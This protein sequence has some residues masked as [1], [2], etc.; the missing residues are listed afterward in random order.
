MVHPRLRFYIVVTM[1]LTLAPLPLAMAGTP[2]WIELRPGME[3]PFDLQVEEGEGLT[4]VRLRVH[5]FYRGLLD[6][7]GSRFESVTIPGSGTLRENGRPELPTFG[8]S[9]LLGTGA[10]VVSVERETVTVDAIVPSPFVARPKRCTGT[11]VERLTCDTEL[12]NGAGAFPESSFELLQQGQFRGQPAMALELRP[13][14]FFPEQRQL[15]V[16]VE[17]RVTLSSPLLRKANARLLSESFDALSR[18]RFHQL[19]GPTRDEG[20]KE[21]LLLVVHDDLLSSVEDFV[22]WKEEKGYLVVVMPLS[23][24]GATHVELKATLQNA[25]D[26]WPLP[27]TYVL[28]LGDGNGAGKVPFVPSPYGCASDFLFSTLDGDDLYSDVLVGRVSAHTVEEAE[29]QLGKAIWYERDLLANGD[30]EWLPR[31]ICISSSEGSGPSNDDV[32]SEIIC[33]LQADYGFSPTDRLYHSNG[34]DKAA[35]ISGKIEEGRGWLTYLGH[36]S[37]HSW[38]TTEPPYGTLEVTAL[39]NEYRLPFVV[40]VSCSN[41]EFD[42]NAGDCF[43]EVWMKTG[44]ANGPRAAIA[45]YSAS[46]VTPWDEPAEMAVGMTKAALEEGIYGWSALAAA[47]RSYMMETVPGGSHEEVCHQYVVFGDPSLQVRTAQPRVLTVS[48]PPVLPLG[49]FPFAVVVSSEDLPVAGATVALSLP[50]G[51]TV[52]AKTAGDGKA[53]LEVVTGVVGEALLTVTAA[54]AEPYQATLDTLVPGCGLLQATPAL[55]Q[56]EGALDVQ[57]FD[58]DLNL[59][60][61]ALDGVVV[62]ASSDS[63]PQGI[64]VA[65]VETKLDS[66]KFV[67]GLT[68]SPSGEGEALKVG[69]SETVTVSYLDEACEDGAAEKTVDVVVDCTAPALSELSIEEVTATSGIVSFVTN[70]FASGTVRFGLFEPLGEEV[71]YG[72]GKAHSVVLSGLSPDSEIFAEVSLEDVAGNESLDDN[73]GAYYV[74]ETLPCSP[75]CEGKQCGPDGCGALCGGCCEGQTCEAG[76]CLGGPGCEVAPVPGCSE[77]SCE[78]CVCDVDPYCCQVMWD[79]LCVGECVDQCGGCGSTP[80]CGEKECGPNGCGG[81][82]GE[83]PLGW[84]CTDG[85]KCVDNCE[86]DCSGSDC[87][88]DGCGGNCGTCEEG[89]Q[90]VEGACLEECGGIDFVGCCDGDIQ[91]YCEDGFQLLVDCA[92]Q[93]LTCGWKETLGWYDCSDSSLSDPSGTFPLW[94]PGVCPPECDGKECGPDGCGG[95]CGECQEG[96]ECANALCIQDC[97]PNCDGQSCGDDGCG[98]LCECPIGTVCDGGQCVNSCIPQCTDLDCGDDS[99]EGSCGQCAPG[100]SCSV[101]QCVLGQVDDDIVQ[102]SDVI[103]DIGPA[104]SQPSSGCSAGEGANPWGAIFM[105][106]LILVVALSRRTSLA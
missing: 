3:H 65:L 88:T 95:S 40:D 56:C 89:A 13:F 99:C 77:C 84:D 29:R 22:A 33:N 87:G 28:L 54:N 12:Y 78:D 82:C 86:A 55:A 64:A 25:Y 5:G 45:I 81:V 51:G 24:A 15:E 34:T 7:E 23:E 20:G 66:G 11:S 48:H 43:A 97:E 57:L 104:P 46:M 100:M 4:T 47:G 27:P 18:S 30:G 8:V 52:V 6:P 96:Q 63:D 92:A 21:L 85:G 80:T 50:G 14:R 38:S 79:D 71:P 98:G 16:A 49:S 19:L 9:L 37:G 42:S 103:E 41:G 83:C 26:N 68:I 1:L 58:A 75:Q 76:A 67:G 36:G 35:T 60:A 74:F 59:S 102:E 101:G 62:S 72:G 32:R 31:A 39:Q 90:C 61:T 17:L 91:H 93:G 70:E 105:F 44:E 2:D 53:E 69:D 106:C 94:C 73:D 10:E